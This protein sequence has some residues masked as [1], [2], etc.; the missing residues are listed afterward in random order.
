MAT[1]GYFYMAIDTPGVP[2][3]QD[4]PAH[5]EMAPTAISAITATGWA[6]AHRISPTM[7]L[8]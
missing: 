4:Q 5:F 8:P 7:S 6:R 3:R 1:S 2:D